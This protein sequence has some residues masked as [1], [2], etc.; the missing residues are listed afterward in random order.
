MNR[1]FM[2]LI[3]FLVIMLQF[4]L[5][6]GADGPYVSVNLGV[7]VLSESDL[8][9]NFGPAQLDYDLGFTPGLSLGQDYGNIRIEAEISYL[10]NGY[11]K[12]KPAGNLLNSDGDVET[13]VFM[14]NGFYDFENSSP[15]TPYAGGG[16]GFAQIDINDFSVYNHTVGNDEDT[17][18]AYQ[19]GAGINYEI[20]ES[21]SLDLS[22]KYLVTD[23]PELMIRGNDPTFTVTESEYKTHRICAGIR[24]S[25]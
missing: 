19:L 22:Y 20:S 17:V 15:F 23:D 14:L 9:T 16:I 13:W 3:V 6:F 8:T 1:K 25:Y 18:F 4:S 11:D 7:N 10:K 2:G 12:I 5:T 21:I 24:V